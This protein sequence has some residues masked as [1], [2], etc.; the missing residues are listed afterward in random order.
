MYHY[1]GFRVTLCKRLFIQTDLNKELYLL[2][3]RFFKDFIFKNDTIVY[4]LKAGPLWKQQ[5][6]CSNITNVSSSSTSKFKAKVV[7]GCV[8][9]EQSSKTFKQVSHCL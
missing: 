8:S 3:L 1:K 9:R 6:S 2:G 4:V 5:T 7:D